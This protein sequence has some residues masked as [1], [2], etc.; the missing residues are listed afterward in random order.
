MRILFALASILTVAACGGDDGGPPADV[1][2]M[3]TL[4]TTNGAN[5]CMFDRWNAGESAMNI[6]L[7]LTQSGSEFHATLGGAGAVAFDL[8]F[9]RHDFDGTVSGEHLDGTLEGRMSFSMGTCTA[10]LNGHME[11][12][13]SGDVITG[14]FFYIPQTNDAADCGVLNSCEN[15]Q[16]F[17]G[18]RP[19]SM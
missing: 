11:A 5:D 14:T 4:A 1:A 19:P 10:T 17:N 18:T 15:E 9:G 13:L 2:G 6:P 8:S 7:T 12:T 3:F 16:Q